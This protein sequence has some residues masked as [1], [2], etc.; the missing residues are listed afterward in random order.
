MCINRGHQPRSRP[1]DGLLNSCRVSIVPNLV[2][3]KSAHRGSARER[4]DH[5]ALAQASH[6]VGWDWKRGFVDFAFQY[7]QQAEV[8]KVLAAYAQEIAEGEGIKCTTQP[9]VK[10][11]QG[12]HDPHFLPR[13]TDFAG[14]RIYVPLLSQIFLTTWKWT[15]QRR[16]ERQEHDGAEMSLSAVVRDAAI[17][18]T[19]T[20]SRISKYAQA[21][22]PKGMSFNTVPMNA[23]SGS[24]GGKPIA[25][26]LSDFKFIPQIVWKC[27]TPRLTLRRI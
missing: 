20:G 2:R 8:G 10:T 9:H 25:F 27:T 11:I 14:K 6:S 16:P 18:G 22:I 12:Y 13:L 26:M 3:L 15:P 5:T 17:L 7:T 23:A 21:Q 19:F 1:S 4:N 24:D